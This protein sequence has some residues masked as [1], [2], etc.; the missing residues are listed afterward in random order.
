MHFFS[1]L[2]LLLGLLVS[3]VHTGTYQKYST[4]MLESIISRDEGVSAADGLLGEI[5]KVYIILT[6]PDFL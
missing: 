2:Y 3:T 4:W 1:I 5:Q 6:S